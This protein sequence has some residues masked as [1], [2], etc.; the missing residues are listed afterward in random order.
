[1]TICTKRRN[2]FGGQ[3]VCLV[4][5]LQLEPNGPIERCKITVTAVHFVTVRIVLIYFRL[6]I[7][8]SE[9]NYIT[10]HLSVSG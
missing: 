9:S 1:M 2:Q 8:D 5:N 3:G 10:C 4:E 7:R 6:H